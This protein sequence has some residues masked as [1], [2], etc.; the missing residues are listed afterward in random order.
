MPS[1]SL[2]GGLQKVVTPGVYVPPPE[3]YLNISQLID[4][5]KCEYRWNLGYNRGISTRVVNRAPEV[6]SAVHAGLAHVMH[7][8][9]GVT[10]WR[11]TMLPDAIKEGSDAATAYVE[12]AAKARGGVERMYPEE[13]ETYRDALESAPQVLERSLKL[14]RLERFKIV[15]FG[16]KPM[17]EMTFQSPIAKH[18]GWLGFHFTIDMVMDDLERGGRWLWDYKCRKAFTTPEDEEVNLQFPSYQEG[19]FH[20][21]I[22]T[23][24]AMMFQVSSKP[25]ATPKLNR[26]GTMSKADIHC[27][28]DTYRAALLEKG[29]NPKDYKEMEGKLK[30]KRFTAE[31]PVYRNRAEVGWIWKEIIEKGATRMTASR[32]QGGDLRSMHFMG[33]KGCWARKFCIAELKFE[34]TDFLLSTDYVDKKDPKERI[35]LK[36][37][38][39]TFVD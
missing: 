29:L 16:K 6:G 10:R 28:W 12:A 15:K 38:D 23:V 7:M 4:Y 2:K 25:E 31:E 1:P 37:E 5:L 19:L 34:D 8:H 32:V 20:H 35:I 26:D 36:P 13:I 14:L 24:G 17:I 3:G 30:D 21:G 18:T 9:A 33:C 11:K 22:E 27:S 39:M